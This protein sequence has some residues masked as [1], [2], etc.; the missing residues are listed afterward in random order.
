MNSAKASTRAKLRALTELRYRR[1]QLWCCAPSGVEFLDLGGGNRLVGL[2]RGPIHGLHP[3]DPVLFVIAGKDH[4]ISLFDCVKEGPTAIQTCWGGGQSPCTQEEDHNMTD[5]MLY[6]NAA[7][8]KGFGH[9]SERFKWTVFASNS[10]KK[11][12][13]VGGGFIPNFIPIFPVFLYSHHLSLFCVGYIRFV[14]IHF[15]N[16]RNSWL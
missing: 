2:T 10:A 8:A 3:Q 7:L 11:C 1:I 15:G 5:I 12:G 16:H 13:F 9:E 14:W 4:S 6:Y